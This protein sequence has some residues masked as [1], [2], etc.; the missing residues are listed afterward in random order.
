MNQLEKYIED[1]VDLVREAKLIADEL[2]EPE[3]IFLIKSRTEEIDDWRLY[4]SVFR[5]LFRQCSNEQV[6]KVVEAFDIE[7]LDCSWA[8]KT[9]L[10]NDMKNMFIRINR[11]DLAMEVDDALRRL[12]SSPLIH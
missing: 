5:H 12:P 2:L 11:T 9:F 4:T 6:V 8:M 1:C 10:L 3:N 7:K